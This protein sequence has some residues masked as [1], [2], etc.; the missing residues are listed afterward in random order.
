MQY[1]Q[2]TEFLT[3]KCVCREFIVPQ[4]EKKPNFKC[5]ICQIMQKNSIKCTKNENRMMN[6][7]FFTYEKKKHLPANPNKVRGNNTDLSHTICM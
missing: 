6:E 3:V 1:S 4:R 2:K 7:R 5:S